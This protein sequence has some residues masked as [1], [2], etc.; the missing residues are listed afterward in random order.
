MD[1]V[2]DVIDNSQY[3][4]LVTGQDGVGKAGLDLLENKACLWGEDR[5]AD[6]QRAHRT[7]AEPGF[8]HGTNRVSHLPGMGFRGV[9]VSLGGGEPS[10]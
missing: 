6:Q 8:S 10:T 3:I 2:R 1:T 9:G 5:G 7:R 4:M